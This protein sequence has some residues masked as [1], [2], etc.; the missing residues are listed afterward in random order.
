QNN[1]SKVLY[2]KG[3]GNIGVMQGAPKE[4]FS[5]YG[6]TFVQ[7]G[8]C[9]EI[10]DAGLSQ[11]RGHNVNPPLQNLIDA[12]VI[13]SW[14]RNFS[15]TSPH[16]YAKVKD[17]TF[18]TI[19]P[20]VTDM[21]KKSDLHI[22]LNPKTDHELALLL[23]RFAYMDDMNDEESYEQYSQGAE[24]FLDLAQ[25]RPLVSYEATVGVHLSQIVKF[26]DLIKNK[27]VAIMLG[28]GIQKYYEGAQ[29]IRAIDSFAAYIG[30]H[31]KNAGGVWYLSDASYGY[32]AQFKTQAKKSVDITTVDFSSYEMV[33]I[34]GAN[35]VVSIP[36]T[37]NVINGLKDT[38]VVYFGTTFND[39]CEYADLIIPSSDFLSKLDIRLSYGHENKAISYAVK[40]KNINMLSEYELTAFLLDRFNYEPLK[41]ELEIFDYYKNTSPKLPK[42]DSF[43]FI[44]ELEIEPLYEDKEENQ[45]YLITGKRKNSLNSQ[46]KI[47]NC[48][49]FHP[50]CGYDDQQEVILS[51]DHG[52]ANFIVKHNIDI[53]E[54][55]ILIHAGAKKGNYLTPA[56]S[57]E[58]AFSAIFQDVLVSIDLP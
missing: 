52:K 51:T 12:D 58:V 38:F 56:Q 32:E 39:T 37:R 29:I 22:Q 27:K 42:I 40:E 24:E 45:F 23:T 57:D 5:Q 25:S 2:Y 20:I 21:A 33:F 54:N 17:K 48:A 18:I 55:C 35:P 14:G 49:Y 11:G 44:E 6:A 9:D 1:A 31:N 30:V 4:F 26:M 41:S 50:S 19:D 15:I 36:N 53:K 46:F 8:I 10:G 3:S 43:E 7:G 13:I 28:L 34:Q 47:D 16:M